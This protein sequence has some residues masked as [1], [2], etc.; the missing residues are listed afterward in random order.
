M[1]A[2]SCESQSSAED[3]SFIPLRVPRHVAVRLFTGGRQPATVGGARAELG[4]H[5]LT[6]ELLE[7]RRHGAHRH[8]LNNAAIVEEQEQT[9]SLHSGTHRQMGRPVLLQQ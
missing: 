2:S 9:T 4:L 5:A 6:S 1:V 3:F 7:P 8:A